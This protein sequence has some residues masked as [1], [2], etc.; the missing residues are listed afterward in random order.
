MLERLP[1]ALRRT[2]LLVVL[3]VA[4]LFA[5]RAFAQRSQQPP[6]E[7]PAKPAAGIFHPT[8][9]QWAALNVA[10]VQ[11]LSFRSH[12]STDGNIAFNEDALTPVFSPYSGRVSR[13]FA[14]LGDVV[15]KGAPLMAVDAAEFVQGQSDVAAAKAGLELARAT[16]KRQHDLFEAGA[17]ALKD[18]RQAQADLA[19]AQA[20]HAAARGRLRILGKT[21]ADIDAL[22]KG[23]AGTTEAIVTTPISGTV[24]QRQV[25]LGQYI[26]SAATGAAAPLFTIG[27]LT[28]VWLVANVRESDAPALRVGQPVEVTV[29]AVPGRTF[30]AKIDLVGAAVDAATHRLPVRAAVQ[31]RDGRLKPLMFASFSVATSEAVQAPAVPQSAIIYEGEKARVFVALDDGSIVVRN[32]RAGRRQ[33]DMIEIVDGLHAGEKVV[34]AGTLFVDRAAAGD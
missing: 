21:E 3:A 19:A 8:K 25:G 10:E 34:T 32:V 2:L 26:S 7:A 1:P 22:E 31:N 15:K 11:A 28:T 16:E 4:A 13:L 27:D 33:N 20:A 9:E 30:A 12:F 29:L 17:A 18:W 5:W 6:P 24:T 14:K 23:A